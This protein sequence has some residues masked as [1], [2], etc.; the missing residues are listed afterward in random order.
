MQTEL[1]LPASHLAYIT[2]PLLF[3]S[4]CTVFYLAAIA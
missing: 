3:T 2:I 1:N 4:R